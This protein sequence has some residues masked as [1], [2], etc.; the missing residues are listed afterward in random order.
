MSTGFV[1]YDD[2]RAR[3]LQPFALTRPAGELRAG[4]EL[5][6]ER[7]ERATGVAASG[8]LSA[9]HLAGFAEAG[10]RPCVRGRI[11]AGTILVNARCAPSLA[12]L[13]HGG[14]TTFHLPRVAGRQRAKSDG[15]VDD[16]LVGFGG[17]GDLRL[18]LRG[19]RPVER[20]GQIHVHRHR[21][22]RLA[23]VELEVG[24]RLRFVE[25]FGVRRCGVLFLRHPDLEHVGAVGKP[26]HR[27][28]RGKS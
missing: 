10:R 19:G 14:Q 24:D 21:H 6:R 4:A 3:A 23:A 2:A 13:P 5:I 25:V 16:V 20:R 8:F 18:Q 17:C 27:W 26:R 15:H 12:P 7:W 9:P 11:A 22:P 1:L 28:V